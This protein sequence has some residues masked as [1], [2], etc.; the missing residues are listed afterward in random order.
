M[1][2]NVVFF[3]II[4]IKYVEHLTTYVCDLNTACIKD[5][6]WNVKLLFSLIYFMFFSV[7]KYY[8]GLPIKYL[9]YSKQFRFEKI[10]TYIHNYF[11]FT[12]GKYKQIY[13]VIIEDTVQVDTIT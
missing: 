5:F 9:L 3:R 2:A 8:F 1:L 12:F 7:G 13:H 6:A 10:Y 11:N 4:Y